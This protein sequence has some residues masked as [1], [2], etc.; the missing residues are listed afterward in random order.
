[1]KKLNL[2]EEERRQR[3]LKQKRQEYQ[4]NKERYNQKSKEYHQKNREKILK[5]QHE[6]WLKIRDKQNERRRK[7]YNEI[8]KKNPETMKRKLER[9]RNWDKFRREKVI[10]NYSQGKNCCE[11]CGENDFDVLAIDHIN[12][13]GNKHRK[14]IARHTV[15]YLIKNNFPEGYRVLCMNCNIKEAKRKGF[16]GTRRFL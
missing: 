14:E 7:R 2:T 12:G 11:I 6:H 13:G 5:Q 10:Y 9:A 16:F 8:D 15:D 4:R 3:I 1:M